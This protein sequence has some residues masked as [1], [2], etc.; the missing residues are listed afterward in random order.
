MSDEFKVGFPPIIDADSRILI[1][2]TLPGDP[3]LKISQYYGNPGNQF[4]NILFA[5][6]GQPDDLSYVSKLQFLREHGIALWDV[7]HRAKRDGSE[8]SKIDWKTAVMNDFVK[9][10]DA[11]QS[12]GGK[13]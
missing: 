11:Y 6:Y 5:I 12:H 10:F 4:W 7:I 2:G 3:S 8:D 9:L 1:L 13:N